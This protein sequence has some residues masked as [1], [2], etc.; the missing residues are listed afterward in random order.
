[1]DVGMQVDENLDNAIW[2]DMEMLHQSQ[3]WWGFEQT[4][5]RVP[6]NKW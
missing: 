2:W 1:M 5:N 6:G 4:D 3:V